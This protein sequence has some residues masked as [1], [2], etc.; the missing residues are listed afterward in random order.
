MSEPSQAERIA[1]LCAKRGETLAQIEP[2]TFVEAVDVTAT[3]SPSP[4]RNWRQITITKPAPQ[5]VV[6]TGVSV[7]SFAAMA[8]GP[9]TD[10]TVETTGADDAQVD[11]AAVDP[12]IAQVPAVPPEVVV[13]V[14][15]NYIAVSEDGTPLPAGMLLPDGTPA[16]PADPADP[17][18]PVELLGEEVQHVLAANAAPAGTVAAA[19]PAATAAPATAAPAETPATTTPPQTTQAPATTAAPTTTAAPATTAPPAA[20][21]PPPPPKSEASG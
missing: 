15:P 2:P 17:G 20:T 7:V 4:Q 21:N 12:T 10:Q 3:P 5:R 16:A 6:A 19:A 18:A 8:M 11:A 13:E 14:I 9:L 1:A